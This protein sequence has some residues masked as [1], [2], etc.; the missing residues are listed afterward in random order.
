MEKL[1]WQQ[2]YATGIRVIDNDHKMLFSIVNNLV[3]EVNGETVSESRQ[4]DSLLEALVEYVDSHFVREELFLEQFGYPKLD[5]HRDGHDA[6]RHQVDAIAN[7]YQT[8]PDSIDLEKVCDF[9]TKWLSEHILESDM[10]YVPYLNGE[11]KGMEPGLR[12]TSQQVTVSVPMG[13]GRLIH[14]LAHE[15]RHAQDIDAAIR[16]FNDAHFTGAYKKRSF[17]KSSA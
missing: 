9:L 1:D 13:T 11:K 15:L 8:A 14:E 10:D 12:D 5:E 3:S 6:L 4:I 17:L 16:H 7:D 2:V